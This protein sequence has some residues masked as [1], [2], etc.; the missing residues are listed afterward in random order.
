MDNAPPVYTIQTCS[1]ARVLEIPAVLLVMEKKRKKIKKRDTVVFYF[2][3]FVFC[4]N[5]YNE[6]KV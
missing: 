4:A 5:R 6:A 3:L 1:T 2:S